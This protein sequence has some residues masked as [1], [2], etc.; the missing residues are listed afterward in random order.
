[1][2]IKL[3]LISLF[4][5]LL[6]AI[7]VFATQKWK[8][9]SEWLPVLFIMIS[10]GGIYWL[11]TLGAST[12]ELSI[13]VGMPFTISLRADVLGVYLSLITCFVWLMAALYSVEY[14]EHRKTI[15]NVFMM[16]SLFGMLGINLTGNLFSLLLFFE[17]FSVAS[18]I[19]IIHDLTKEAITASFQFLFISILGSVAMIFSA[20]LIYQV[21]GTLDLG[22]TG[23][24]AL[25][26]SP[27]IG[28][29]FWLLILGF[30]IKAGMF[31]AHIWLPVA[32]PI[33]PSSASALLSG[34]MIKA[35]AYGII[36]AIYGVFGV[37]LLSTKPVMITMIILAVIT[38]I[39]GSLMA[40][41]QQELKRLLAYSS[42]AQIGYVILGVSLM[43]VSGLTGGVFHI[44]VH[45]FMKG[46]LFFAAGAIIHK[47]GLRQLKD[48][49]GIGRHMPI[50]MFAITLAGLSMI[51]IPPFSGF[52]SKWLLASGALEASNIGIISR[53]GAY[54]IIGALVLSGLLNVIYY[55]PII[56]NGWL[57]KPEIVIGGGSG[58]DSHGD[59]HGHGEEVAV[60]YKW[61]EP[62]WVMLFPILLLALGTLFFGIYPSLPMKL[63][64]MIARLYV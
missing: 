48:L 56:I 5:P 39:F 60:K 64:Q 46:S 2:A 26:S 8:K 50:T 4:M 51:G 17:L 10:F 7:V 31:P 63:A 1:M 49:K 12:T 59:G 30:A 53:T 35:G 42:I 43:T 58:H 32:H 55:G 41:S 52:L 3:L 19:L 33:A 34:V 36:R 27:Y 11:Y 15:F 25:K 9:V 28:L 40:I 23:I 16:L 29:T 20:V 45:A 62:S 38:M 18:A 44:F 13:D 6:G 54:G 24:V 47:T 61:L 21:A 22:G 57:K 37:S 14:I